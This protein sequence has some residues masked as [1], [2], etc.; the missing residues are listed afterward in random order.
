MDIEISRNK[1]VCRTVY[2][3]KTLVLLVKVNMIS[4]DIREPINIYE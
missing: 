1:G 3:L 4:Y 2:N